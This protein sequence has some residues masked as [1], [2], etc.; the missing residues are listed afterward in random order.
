M[1]LSIS[2]AD[3]NNRQMIDDS[4]PAP[5]PIPP[6]TFGRLL[7]AAS[8]AFGINLLLLLGLG[9]IAPVAL[10]APLATGY[11]TGW[12]AAASK[13]Q[14]L[15]IGAL[16][17]AMMLTLLIVVAAAFAIISNAIRG[18]RLEDSGIVFSIGAALVIHLTVFA[19]VGAMIGGHFARRSLAAGRPND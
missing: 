8:R 2:Y 7:L 5:L 16:M 13:L 10:I 6:L 12:K 14:G 9:W 11:V 18:G 17:G 4:T 19:S 3:G 1:G 15:M